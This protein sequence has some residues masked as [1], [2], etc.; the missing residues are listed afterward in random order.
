MASKPK[1]YLATVLNLATVPNLTSK[2][3]LDDA[4]RHKAIKATEKPLEL[5]SIKAKLKQRTTV[6]YYWPVTHIRVHST[7]A[8]EPTLSRPTSKRHFMLF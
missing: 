2:P 6:A 4:S 1:E 8:S 3:N 7:L 5:N